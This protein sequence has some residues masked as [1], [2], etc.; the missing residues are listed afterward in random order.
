MTISNKVDNKTEKIVELKTKGKILSFDVGILNLAYCLVNYTSD[1]IKIEEW[2]IINLV[3]DREK[4]C[5][6]LKNG[7]ICGSIGRFKS[8]D[9]N[10][11]EYITCKKHKDKYLPSI[12]KAD[13][14]DKDMIC[15]KCK[16]N[17]CVTSE[18]KSI[19][20]CEKH[21]KLSKSYLT[22]FKPK[23][24]ANQDCA[25]QPIQ[26]LAYKLF[27]ELDSH[28]SFLNVDEV[29]IENQPSLLNPTMKTI[30]SFLYS[31][32]VMRGLVDKTNRYITNIKFIS[33]SN[34]LKV[35]KTNTKNKLNEAKTKRD[36]YPITK[37][38]GIIYCKQLITDNEYKILLKYDKKDDMCDAFLQS[39]HYIYQVLLCSFPE[40][41]IKKLSE[42][43]DDLLII[44]KA[45][46]KTKKTTKKTE[47]TDDNDDKKKTIKKKS[48]NTT[49]IK[50]NVINVNFDNF[51]IVKLDSDG[52]E[53]ND[54]I[55]N[56]KNN[57]KDSIESLPIYKKN[58]KS[59]SKK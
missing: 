1:N 48:K 10:K 27:L 16:N 11:A 36:E 54:N 14:Y 22:P 59:K 29:L 35:D 5:Y 42:I 7:R 3:N 33:P 45:K 28:K 23:K 58:T 31:Y 53:I 56:N 41:Y 12:V 44:K 20:W 21:E 6:V 18:D 4:C 25:S 2:G 38:L 17:C 37:T 40:H 24:I 46:R 13:K 32:F 52:N 43:P 47:N 34:K 8:I 15:V 50:K 51:Q 49:E 19:G 9:L 57:D 26:T 39:F 30:S 55:N